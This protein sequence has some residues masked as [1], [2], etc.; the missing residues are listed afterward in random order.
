MS[1]KDRIK[2]GKKANQ[3]VTKVWFSEHKKPLIL[4]LTISFILYGATI[5]HEF[6]LDDYPTVVENKHVQE[7]IGGV[8]MILIKAYWHGAYGIN[9]GVYRPISQVMFAVEKSFLGGG[10]G[11]MHFF[12]VLLYGLT[13]CL[14]FIL[15]GRLFSAT[16]IEKHPILKHLP[17]VA[18]ILFMAHPVHVEV[19]ANVKGRDEI[20][21]FIF[22]LLA[23]VKFFDA[24][25]KPKGKHAL[26][27]G[28]FFLLAVLS[29]ES[30]LAFV[31]IIP[32]S[33]YVFTGK[34]PLKADGPILR[35]V[36][37]MIVPLLLRFILLDDFSEGEV[38]REIINNT[39]FGAE[40]LGERY[41]TA[42]A[43][44]A[45]YIHMLIL[46]LTLISDYSYS[47]IP[48]VDWSHTKAIGGLVIYG[49]S[50]IWALTQIK[51]RNVVAFWIL[52]YLGTMFIVSNL[53]LLIGSTMADRFLYV[54][55]LAFAVGVSWCVLVI[56]KKIKSIKVMQISVAIAGLISVGY[57]FKVWERASEWE[58]NETLFVADL[59]KSPN[60]A[61]MNYFLGKTYFIKARNAKIP[62]VVKANYLKA[63]PRMEKSMEIYPE[64]KEAPQELGMAYLR[65]D[66]VDKALFWMQRS[67]E[68][69]PNDVQSF[70]YLGQ[71][72]GMKKNPVKAI[73]SLHKALEIEPGNFDA[74]KNMAVTHAMFGN[75]NDALTAAKKAEGTSPNDG[76]IRKLLSQIYSR[77]GDNA[78]A[79]KYRK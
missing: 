51:K 35:L 26:W 6:V 71:F 57:A 76:S 8:G 23:W 77:L 34:N 28:I 3:S 46:P 74:M 72:Y 19:V 45:E 1:K 68:L 52:F 39:L 64:F 63:I 42:F 27:T 7:G 44:L 31:V 41:A 17:L 60:N 40:T 73:E 22:V 37:A 61:K 65:T 15:L 43:I 5:N 66:N 33:Y 21:A 79:N 53:V 59:E 10:P 12:N 13:G 38:H 62:E 14:L 24:L 58:N 54:P 56:A 69:K 67:V 47:H 78:N 48:I 32:L 30:A 36:G 50:G 49:G 16:W 70:I 9:E 25:E 55:S 75:F 2:K 29:K 11:V 4:F 18:T 20:L